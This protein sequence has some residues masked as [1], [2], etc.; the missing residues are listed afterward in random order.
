MSSLGD[1]GAGGL[2]GAGT[3][4][5]AQ[6]SSR[7]AGAGVSRLGVGRSL[8]VPASLRRRGQLSDVQSDVWCKD[9]GHCV[10]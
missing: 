8:V 1:G 7:S 3:T 10:R 4:H 9:A 6:A 5:A 2:G